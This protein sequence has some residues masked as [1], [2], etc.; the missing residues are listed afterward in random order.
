MLVHDLSKRLKFSLLSYVQVSDAN[1]QVSRD[2]YHN[3]C[4]LEGCTVL[5]WKGAK[6]NFETLMKASLQLGTEPFA[7]ECFSRGDVKVP[8][9]VIKRTRRVKGES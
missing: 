7:A 6:A 9:V 3:V 2:R 8:G 4:C 1:T 5:S